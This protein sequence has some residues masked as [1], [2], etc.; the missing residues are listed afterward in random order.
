MFEFIDVLFALL[1]GVIFTVIMLILGFPLDKWLFGLIIIMILMLSVGYVYKAYIKK[2]IFKTEDEAV[3][4]ED[5]E[6]Q[7][8]DI[9]AIEQD[10]IEETSFEDEYD[11][12]Y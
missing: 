7:D 2:H 10:E 5:I 12:E 1:A 4:E 9:E 8:E 11:E 3:V 6:S